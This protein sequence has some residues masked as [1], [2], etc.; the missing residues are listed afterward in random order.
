LSQTTS[1]S[2]TEGVYYCAA[3]VGHWLVQKRTVRS[4]PGGV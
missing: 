4:V 3:T 1:K 2:D